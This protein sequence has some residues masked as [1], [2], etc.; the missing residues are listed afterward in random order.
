MGV[1]ANIFPSEL[2]ALRSA[3]LILA[4]GLIAYAV[5]R[6]HS[7]RN[8][9][10]VILL[11]SGIALAVVAGT[12]VTDALLSAFAMRLSECLGKQDLLARL[13]G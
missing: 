8:A 11:L 1:Q 2:T 9:D 4:I 7:L 6:R 13:G 5:A 3:G 10:I 12:E